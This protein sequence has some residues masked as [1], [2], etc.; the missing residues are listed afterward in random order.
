MESPMRG[1]RSQ[2]VVVALLGALLV[3]AHADGQSRSWAQPQIQR[4][5]AD[6]LMAPSVAT[7]RPNDPLLA[8]ELAQL[9]PALAPVDPT[10]TTPTVPTT[11]DTTTATTTDGTTTAATT[12]ATT[13]TTPAPA[14]PPTRPIT[15]AQL[16]ASLVRTL[17]AGA[18]A[19]RFARATRAVG[20]RPPARF[21]TEVVARLLG[22]RTNHPAAQ[23]SLE[24]R[25]Q[26]AITRAETAYSVA[27]ILS[28]GGSELASVDD[29]SRLFSLPPLDPWQQ[30]ILQTAVNLIGYPYVWGGTSPAPEAPMGHQVRG[31]F[32][33]SGFVWQVYK[34][35]AY[36]EEGT[37]AA[38]LRGRTTYEMSG[39]VGKAKR[40]ALADLQ[41]ADVIFFGA[42]GPKSK[43]PQVDHMG[44]YLGNGWFVH[45]SGYGVA[46]AQISGWYAERFAWGRRPLAEAG[47]ELAPTG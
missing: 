47:L 27:Q 33:C 5:V 23:D 36:A 30:R 20:L 43:P 4:V 37:L 41:P 2:A 24:L 40:I 3:A 34:L 45:S 1:I 15:L 19:T 7:F 6:G 44:I 39:E 42:A 21:G 46:L 35:H 29:A 22:L 8:D 32:D 12:T 17:K 25:P 38:T 26:D 13:T 16:D 10:T 28:F 9:L 14:A 18:A 31:G 11:T